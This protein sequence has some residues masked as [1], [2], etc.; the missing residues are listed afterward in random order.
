MQQDVLGFD[1]AMD[2]VVPVRVVQRVR[3]LGR[4]L[5]RFVDAELRLAVQLL[6]QRLSSMYGMT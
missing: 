2:H 5:H 3:H 4:D 6:A 1:V